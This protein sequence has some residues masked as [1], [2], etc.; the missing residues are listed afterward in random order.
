MAMHV[1]IDCVVPVINTS[2]Q[3]FCF[4]LICMV[5]FSCSLVPLYIYNSLCLTYDFTLLNVRCWKLHFC[6]FCAHISVLRHSMIISSYCSFAVSG[7]RL[8]ITSLH[9]SCE[10]RLLKL[11]RTLL[12]IRCNLLRPIFV[13]QLLFW[14]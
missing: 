9:W 10:P 6:E 2:F 7:Q 13:L 5:G 8:E 12:K 14:F 4:F 1:Q 11:P 3:A